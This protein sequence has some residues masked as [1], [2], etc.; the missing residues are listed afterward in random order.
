LKLSHSPVGTANVCVLLHPEIKAA[1]I[2]ALAVSLEF[3]GITWLAGA[4]EEG[5]RA[6]SELRCQ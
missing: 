4:K 5:L 3:M 6:G 2:T 1:Q